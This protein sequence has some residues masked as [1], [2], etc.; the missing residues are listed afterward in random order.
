MTRIKA[1]GSGAISAA[2]AAGSSAGASAGAIAQ[3][4]MTGLA[5]KMAASVGGALGLTGN[6]GADQ[7][8]GNGK[9]PYQIEDLV[10]ELTASIGGSASEAGELSRAFH[11]F[12]Q[13]GAALF[14]ARPE[15]RS[16]TFVHSVI[17]NIDRDGGAV[18]SLAAVSHLVDSATTAL[19]GA[20]R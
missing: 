2:Q 15:S 4:A 10:E 14:A 17:G 18:V 5:G 11:A 19:R 7:W 16:L 3:Q 8:Q 1:G 13:E 12:V 9:D 6:A 20:V